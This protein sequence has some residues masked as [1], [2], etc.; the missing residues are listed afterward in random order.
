M[1]SLI[2]NSFHEDLAR[3]ANFTSPTAPFPSP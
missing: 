2:Y 3:D 1:A